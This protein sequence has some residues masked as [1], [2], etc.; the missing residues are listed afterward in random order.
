VDVK[1]EAGDVIGWKSDPGVLCQSPFHWMGAYFLCAALLVGLSCFPTPPTK[2]EEAVI[3]EGRG[4]SA[5][6]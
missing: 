5:S 1:S 3:G 2:E 4:P 6:D